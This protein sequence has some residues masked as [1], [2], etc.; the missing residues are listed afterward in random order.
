MSSVREK[1]AKLKL[2]HSLSPDSRRVCFR[3][4]LSVHVFAFCPRYNILSRSFYRRYV[5]TLLTL[6]EELHFI[7][8]MPQHALTGP[9]PSRC[10]QHRPGSGPVKAGYGMFT[11][12]IF[13]LQ[14]VSNTELW[15]CFVVG[16]NI[17]LNKQSICREFDT[18][19]RPCDNI[20][21][22]YI[23][24]CEYNHDKWVVSVYSFWIWNW[25][26]LTK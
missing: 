14:R 11:K 25:H 10:Y 9:E 24:A 20:V 3:F 8:N 12:T 21:Y 22:M 26:K 4:S 23:D 13:P 7:V 6:C 18:S 19:W 16:M 1:V 17:V 2:T 15:C 5:P